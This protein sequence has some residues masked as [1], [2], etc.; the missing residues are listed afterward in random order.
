VTVSFSGEGT[1]TLAALIAQV[2][3]LGEAVPEGNFI[4]GRGHSGCRFAAKP[5]IQ[6]Y[7]APQALDFQSI[8]ATLIETGDWE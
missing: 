7:S 5:S 3:P 6:G 8:T 2:R 1:L 4:S